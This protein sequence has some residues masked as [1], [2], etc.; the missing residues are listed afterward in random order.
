[1]RLRTVRKHSPDLPGAAAGRFENQMAAVRG[2]TGTLVAGL[3]AGQFDKLAGGGVHDVDVVVVVGA[4]PTEGQQLAV[5]RPRR[6]DDVAFVG[7][8]QLRVAGAVGIHE[9][10]L[11]S[12]ATIADEGDGLTGFQI[13]TGRHAGAVGVGQPFGAAAVD[14]GD[15]K[16]GIALHRR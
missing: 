5:G 10:E 8:I 13:P 11:G 4:A 12:A 16:L 15:V 14:V 6:V 7:Q 3:V 2:P 1:M 9:V